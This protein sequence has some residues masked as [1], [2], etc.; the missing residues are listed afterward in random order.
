MLNK[1]TWAE[2]EARLLE[3]A[4]TDESKVQS[5]KSKV[6]RA[7]NVSSPARGEFKVQQCNKF[8]KGSV[9]R[10]FVI[11][12]VRHEVQQRRNGVTRLRAFRVT[13]YDQS[14]HDPLSAHAHAG[15]VQRR[16]Q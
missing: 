4:L 2:R 12:K 9:C 11:F 16:F 5:L 6:A 15:P 8:S 1:E 14:L 7:P 10:G 13:G 3:E